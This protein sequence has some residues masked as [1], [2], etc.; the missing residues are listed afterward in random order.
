MDAPTNNEIKVHYKFP[1]IGDCGEKVLEVNN[2][3]I[4]YNNKPLPLPKINMLIKKHMHVAILGKN[5]IG[6]TTFIKTIL[7]QIPQID[8]NYKILNGTVVNYFSQDE[9]FDKSLTPVEYL[10]SI[11]EDKTPLELRTILGSAGVKSN[12]AIRPMNQLSGGEVAKTMLAKMMLKKA[13][14]LI[15]DEPTNHLDQK[16]K[17]ALSKCDLTELENFNKDIK[18]VIHEIIDD[19]I[20][21]EKKKQN[22]S[23]KKNKTIIKTDEVSE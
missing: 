9:D 21:T 15:F 8:G 6:K 2:L 18:K 7:G 20:V 16:A 3:L 17:E 23:T 22:T 19:P 13:N 12:L 1:F 11:Y 5:G 4:G 10:K 14:M